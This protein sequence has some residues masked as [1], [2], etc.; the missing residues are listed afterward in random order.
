MGENYKNGNVIIMLNYLPPCIQN[1]N[2]YCK[3][4]ITKQGKH[5]RIAYSNAKEYF[6]WGEDIEDVLNRMIDKLKNPP[7]DRYII[8]LNWHFNENLGY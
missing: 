1:G 4:N 7:S 2:K 3:L 8:D 6:V 5:Y